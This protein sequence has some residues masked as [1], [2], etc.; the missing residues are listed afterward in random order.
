MG[1]S[2][3]THSSTTQA[4]WPAR[5]ERDWGIEPGKRDLLPF[6][7]PAAS[8]PLAPVKPWAAHVGPRL[9][10]RRCLRR[11]R[12][13]GVWGS[14]EVRHDL[15]NEGGGVPRSLGE[16][17]ETSSKPRLSQDVP[18][19]VQRL[20]VLDSYPG[21]NFLAFF[22]PRSVTDSIVVQNTSQPS[23]PQS[24]TKLFSSS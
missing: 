18:G 10:P 14:R 9:S 24:M 5:E 22:A 23:K 11:R 1:G 20:V 19:K 21:V 7:D 12:S 2:R 8:S 13:H 4:A 17:E 16:G 15:G 3:G 6:R